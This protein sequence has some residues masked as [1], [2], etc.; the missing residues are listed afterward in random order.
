MYAII[1]VFK[2]IRPYE[3]RRELNDCDSH[4]QTITQY[5]QECFLQK[6]ADIEQEI[7]HCY[8]ELFVQHA[9]GISPGSGSGVDGRN[10]GTVSIDMNK[11]SR[12]YA[13]TPSYDIWYVYML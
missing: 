7:A 9:Y 3:Y 2:Y 4:I 1:Q 11:D 12:G 10:G 8:A 6:Q 13:V 5:I